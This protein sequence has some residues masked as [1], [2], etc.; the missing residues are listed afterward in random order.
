MK[1]Q[2]MGIIRHNGKAKWRP[3]IAKMAINRYMGGNIFV[4]VFTTYRF[5]SFHL[6]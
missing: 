2:G 1:F 5:E 6:A 3:N 4:F